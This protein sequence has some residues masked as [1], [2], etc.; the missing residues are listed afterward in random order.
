MS[1][2]EEIIIVS[3][4]PRSGTSMMMQILQAG[5]IRIAYDNQ[6]QADSLNPQG[7]FELEKVKNLQQNNSWIIECKGMAIKVLYHL[8]QFL[9]GQLSYKIIFLNRKLDTIINSQDKMLMNYDKP[10]QNREHVYRILGQEQ[11][12]VKQWLKKQKNMD[13]LY[14]NYESILD[15]PQNSV[16]PIVGFLNR[17]MDILK[18]SQVINV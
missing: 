14:L 16:V 6:R 2:E 7:Y 4:L 5:G 15:D 12:F 8:L 9:P 17:K 10:L 13:V 11:E 1:P 18:M 3:G